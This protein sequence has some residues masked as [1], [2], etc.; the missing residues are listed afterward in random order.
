MF[1]FVG[2]NSGSNSRRGEI[3]VGRISDTPNTPDHNMMITDETPS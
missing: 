1:Q 2:Q 3:K